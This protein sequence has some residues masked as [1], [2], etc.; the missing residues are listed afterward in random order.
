[1]FVLTDAKLLTVSINRKI[2]STSNKTSEHKWKLH[3]LHLKY[4]RACHTILVYRLSKKNV[5]TNIVQRKPFWKTHHTPAPTADGSSKQL[6]LFEQW[7]HVGGSNS[8]PCWSTEQ[9]QEMKCK[10]PRN[11]QGASKRNP[12]SNGEGN[13]RL[14]QQ[15]R[16]GQNCNQA[17]GLTRDACSVL[18]STAITQQKVSEL[19]GYSSRR[20][21]ITC[22]PIRNSSHC[23]QLPSRVFPC[24]KS[25]AE[26]TPY[27]LE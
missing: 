9:W 5:Q 10:K 12:E 16:S 26:K 20:C 17:A 14:T 2:N 21:H 4:N 15:H 7:V 3:N 8:T 6:N 18:A 25:Y 23:P 13:T 27:V 11:K 19:G 24:S 1:M 22:T